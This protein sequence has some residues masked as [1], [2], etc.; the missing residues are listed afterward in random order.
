MEN[1]RGNTIREVLIQECPW[2][3]QFEEIMDGSP[4]VSPPFLM[5][6]GHASRETNTQDELYR[7]Y[8]KQMYQDW[9]D[10]GNNQEHEDDFEGEDFW[11]A[12][13]SHQNQNGEKGSSRDIT[14]DDFSDDNLDLPSVPK[15]ASSIP[16][17]RTPITP[18]TQKAIPSKV[19]RQTALGNKTPPI[20]QK[21][22]GVSQDT[23]WR[24]Q[25]GVGEGLLGAGE[26]FVK[27]KRGRKRKLKVPI[28]VDSD[29]DNERSK[30]KRR[31]KL[32]MAEAVYEGKK[33]DAEIQKREQELRR[34]LA[35]KTENEAKCLHELVMVEAKERR[36]ELQAQAAIRQAEAEE[37]R[38]EAKLR[39]LQFEMQLAAMR[40]S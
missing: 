29:S 26:E 12:S 36:I 11:P 20:S 24:R 10:N 40:N 7:D 15:L 27:G 2:Y 33:I 3:H 17:S 28:Y 35:E 14:D 1:T 6:S 30:K 5:E 38:E 22:T 23:E 16:S 19:H 25:S 8:D 31:S 37:R 4:T 13:Q 32:S 21:D 39:T 9:M 18:C 34:G